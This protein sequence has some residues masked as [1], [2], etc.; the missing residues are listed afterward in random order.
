MGDRQTDRQTDRQKDSKDADLFS[1]SVSK[2]YWFLLKFH[3]SETL[4]IQFYTKYKTS[5]LSQFTRQHSRW[6]RKRDKVSNRA[7]YSAC[8]DYFT[9]TT[10]D[11]ELGRRSLWTQNEI[12]HIYC[13][14]SVNFLRLKSWPDEC[15][16]IHTF[17][18][19]F[20]FKT[21]VKAPEKNRS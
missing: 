12:T 13:V 5:E 9:Q 3:H 10:S 1:L 19:P 14:H 15:Y 11:R 17:L 21:A 20:H 8:T 4:K 7:A 16:S 6:C 2:I 18:L